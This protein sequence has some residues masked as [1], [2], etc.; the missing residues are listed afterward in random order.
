MA[1]SFKR[2]GSKKSET[3]N[4]LGAVGIP[5]LENPSG[6]AEKKK[7]EKKPP[8]QKKSPFTEKTTFV[9]L[10]GDEGTILTLLKKGAVEG[11]WFAP[12]AKEEHLELFN[13]AIQ[14]NEATPFIVF[15]DTLDQAYLQQN[16]PP[17]NRMGAQTIIK[18][19]LKRE[20]GNSEI[21][22]SRLLG[23]DKSKKE[24]FF[25]LMSAETTPNVKA[26]LE[27]ITTTPN[28]CLGV[29]LLPLEMEPVLLALYQKTK[30]RREEPDHEWLYLLS[31]QKVSGFRQVILHKGKMVF[32]RV[33]QPLQGATDVMAGL[34]EQEIGSTVEYLKRLGLRSMDLL[35]LHVIASQDVIKL[36]DPS[37]ASIRSF[38]TSTPHQAAELLEIANATQPAD[39]YGD[40]VTAAAAAKLRAPI[41]NAIT[42]TQQKLATLHQTLKVLQIVP[43]LVVAACAMGVCLELYNAWEAFQKKG[44]LGTKKQRAEQEYKTVES[45]MGLLKD[46]DKIRDVMEV[47]R[48]IEMKKFDPEAFLLRLSTVKNQVGAPMTVKGLSW[49]IDEKAKTPTSQIAAIVDIEFFPKNQG[50]DED[51][52]QELNVF[53]ESMRPFF[54]GYTITLSDIKGIKTSSDSISLEFSQKNAPAVVSAQEV[55]AKLTFTGAEPSAT[56]QESPSPLTPQPLP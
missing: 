30:P 28:R 22:G 26:W 6:A 18:R 43:T 55:T 48:A 3:A 25:Q 33:G 49:E 44:D 56:N 23:R 11:R 4:P 31:H 34:I 47:V 10:V 17:V 39:R 45:E 41:F 13:R 32:S 52:Q 9:L 54:P 51:T 53:V 2:K 12:E 50:G 46:T 7:K 20:F 35:H 40:M 42:K 29:R 14:G 38:I 37:R 36:I 19:R 27:W 16:L 21:K 15:L 24:W 8:K 1:I 5:P